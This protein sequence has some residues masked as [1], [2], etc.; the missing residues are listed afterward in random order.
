MQVALNKD[1]GRG[2][3]SP[4]EDISGVLSVAVLN[5]AGAPIVIVRTLDTPA[6]G[7][8][9]LVSQIG[10]KDFESVVSQFFGRTLEV[11][12]VRWLKPKAV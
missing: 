2:K 1:M 11:P 6:S 10:D 5:D 9:V 7:S 3:F 12:E 8:T 4:R